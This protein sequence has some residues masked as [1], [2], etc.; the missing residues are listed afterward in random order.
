MF[1]NQLNESILFMYHLTNKGFSV[2]DILDGYF[3]YI[4]YIDTMDDDVNYEITK[5]IMKYI[6]HFYSI[7]ENEIELAFFTN[8]LIIILN[9]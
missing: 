6:T 5:L 4:K 3:K 8:E 7:P 9:K 1:K 2:M